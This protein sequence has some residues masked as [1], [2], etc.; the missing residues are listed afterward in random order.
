MSDTETQE[1][2]NKTLIIV[3][4]THNSTLF[5]SESKIIII[6]ILYL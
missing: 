3:K 2:E 5:L 6:L 1:Y 4:P